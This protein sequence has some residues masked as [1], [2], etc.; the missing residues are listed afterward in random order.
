MFS[1]CYTC[2]I[3][4]YTFS[5]D[6][7]VKFFVLGHF[8]FQYEK[9]HFKLLHCDL[10]VPVEYSNTFSSRIKEIDVAILTTQISFAQ[11]S[12]YILCTLNFMML[13]L[14]LIYSKV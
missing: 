9:I 3:K 6:N 11:N 14:K 5:K 2:I 8:Q 13:F 1:Y 12:K 10:H 4:W 7:D